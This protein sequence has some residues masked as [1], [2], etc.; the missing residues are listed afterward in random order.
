MTLLPKPKRMIDKELLE[1]YRSMPCSVW[2]CHSEMEVCAHHLKTQKSGGNDESRNLLAL[3]HFHHVQIHNDG[4]IE[5]CKHHP[6][7]KDQ[8]IEKGWMFD[9]TLQKWILPFKE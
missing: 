4:K 7:I 5:F 9:L 2:D 1:S 6:E 8:L 3:C